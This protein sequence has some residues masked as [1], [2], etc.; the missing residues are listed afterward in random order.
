MVCKFFDK[1][2]GSGAIETSKVE[3]SRNEELAEE[4]H[5]Q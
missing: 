5:N 4:S 1:K 3:M 2:T